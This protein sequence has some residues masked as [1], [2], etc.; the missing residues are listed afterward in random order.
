MKASIAM[1]LTMIQVSKQARIMPEHKLS[2]LCTSDEEISSATSRELIEAQAKEHD[3]V[4]CLEPALPDG[5]LKTQRKGISDFVVEAFG[6]ASHAGAAPEEGVNAVHEMAAQVETITRLAAPK[7]GS[8]VNVN[9]IQ[10]GSRTNVIPASCRIEVDV[11]IT[12]MEEADRIERSMR[13]LKPSLPGATIQVIGGLNRP[14]MMRDEQM[15]RTFQQAKAI[16]AEEIGIELSEGSTG[17]GS[18]ASFVATL[19]IPVLDGLGAIGRGAH[20]ADEYIEVESLVERTALLSA[21][22][23]CW[24]VGS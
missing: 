16:A 18:D 2:L 4:L 1:T 14:P 11:R 20:S 17:G 22:N 9:I 23:Q 7:L 24:P 21:L 15:I 3:L 6:V 19:G 5:A 10:G 13:A 12:T 8:T